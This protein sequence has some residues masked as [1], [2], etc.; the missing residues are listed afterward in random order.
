MQGGNGIETG[1]PYYKNLKG[2]TKD[3]SERKVSLMKNAAKEKNLL[4]T[5]GSDFHGSIKKVEIG[6]SGL[7]LNEFQKLRKSL[8]KA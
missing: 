3:E 6:E 1:Y 2:T 5:A 4:Q 7:T 8:Q